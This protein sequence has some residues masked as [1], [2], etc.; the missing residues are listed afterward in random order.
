MPKIYTKTGDKGTSSLYDGNRIAKHELLFEVLGDIDELSS[1]IGLLYAHNHCKVRDMYEN[2]CY[3]DILKKYNTSLSISNF[4]KNIQK[5]LQNIATEIATVDRT[6]R[7]I[8]ELTEDSVKPLEIE[9]DKMNESLPKLT[10]FVLQGVTQT[11]AQAH[12]CRSVCRRVE[13]HLWKL[14]DS[15]EVIDG[16]NKNVYLEDVNVN[17]SILVYINRLSDYF[18]QLARYLCVVVEEKDEI[19]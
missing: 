1:H 7:K 11:D 4:L 8:L 6:N 19:M 13:R 18:F 12:V 5:T 10:G 3:D 14:D 9:I 16:K 15:K 2:T 17:K